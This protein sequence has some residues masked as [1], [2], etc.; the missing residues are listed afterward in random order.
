MYLFINIIL[1]KMT[2]LKVIVALY[3]EIPERERLLVS[4]YIITLGKG[5]TKL[6]HIYI[7]KFPD[8]I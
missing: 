8:E 1:E 4:C 2:V 6:Q 3:S 7:N 5:S